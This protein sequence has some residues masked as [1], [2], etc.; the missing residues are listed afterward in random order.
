MEAIEIVKLLVSSFGT[1]LAGIYKDTIVDF[2]KS[3]FRAKIIEEGE[4][5]GHWETYQDIKLGPDNLPESKPHPVQ[6]NIT[7]TKV[8]GDSVKGKGNTPN[9]G[10]WSFSG[11]IQ[12]PSLVLSYSGVGQNVK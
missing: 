1:L 8:F 5:S 9:F 4:W 2:F 12:G 6:D 3:L 10:E 7:I 11:R